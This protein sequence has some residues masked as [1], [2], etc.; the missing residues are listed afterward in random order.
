[1]L[2]ALWSTPLCAQDASADDADALFAEGR[3]AMA[4]GDPALACAKLEASQR[5]DPGVGTLL[6]LAD[7]KEALGDLVA[8]WEHARRA[9]AELAA[10]RDDRLGFAERRL[11]ELERR[12][13]RL[14]VRLAPGAPPGTRVLADG[15]PIPADALGARMPVNPGEHVLIAGA[16][17]RGPRSV[18]VVVAEG[19]TEEVTISPGAPPDAA[20]RARPGGGA[21]AQRTWGFVALGVGGAGLIGGAVAG[22]MALDRNAAL[23]EACAPPDRRGERACPAASQG[24][25]DAFRVLRTLSYVGFGVGAASAGLGV[26]LLWTAPSGAT[27]RATFPISPG[28]VGVRCVF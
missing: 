26:A 4:R 15:A 21:G 24:T 12:L 3:E 14:V 16:P 9:G 23:D 27:A 18:R 5:I 28:Y 7:C 20:V 6:N 19:A 11:A 2:A 17:G 22:G 8:A 10:Q 1:M 13:P 25:L